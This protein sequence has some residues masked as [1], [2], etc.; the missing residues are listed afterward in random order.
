VKHVRK[1]FIS[2][3]S[4]DL[5]SYRLAAEDAVKKAG[6]HPV[7]M[8]YWAAQGKRP[9]LEACLREV[10]NCDVLIV[11]VGRRYG[12]VPDGQ[13]RSD[14]KSIAWLECERA[15]DQ[16]HEVIPFLVNENDLWPAEL[17]EEY[18]LV[19]AFK[20][21]R[22]TPE[23][24]AEVK[25][26]IARLDEFK[27]WLSGLGFRGTFTN[28]DELKILVLQALLG[29]DGQPGDATKYLEWLHEFT[30]W[31]DIR[32]LHVGHSKVYRFP[33]RELYTPLTTAAPNRAVAIPDQRAGHV[34]DQDAE[35]GEVRLEQVLTRR[36]VVI[37][38]DAGS[39][40]TT[41]LRR[42][43]HECCAPAGEFAVAP[44]TF[45]IFIR[46]GELEQHIRI[47]ND[48][49]QTGAPTTLES[50]DWLLHFLE[51]R[52]WD[53]NASYFD[54]RM[55]EEQTLVLLD[56]LDEAPNSRTRASMARLFENVTTRYR[57]CRF[58]ITTRPGA[59]H[60]GATLAGFDE[61]KVN[62]LSD[63][64]VERFL[65]HWSTALFPS[66]SRA[67]ELH[68]SE[69]LAAVRTRPGIQLMAHNP[70]MLTA[71]AVLHWNNKRLPEQRAELYEL[72]L[73]WLASARENRPGRASPETCLRL[74]S[75]LALGMQTQASGRVRQLGKRAAAEIILSEFHDASERQRLRVAEEFLDTE[76]VDSGIVVSRGANVEFWHLTF[77]E[78]LAARAIAGLTDATQRDFLLGN[79]RLFEPE[80][81]EIVL[82]YA[83]LLAAK[84]GLDK[85]EAFFSAVLDT[86]S[87]EISDRVRYAALL[88][89]LLVDLKPFGYQPRDSRYREL[90][91]VAMVV[92][93]PIK[94]AGIP[95]ESKV[96]AAEA[97]GRAGDPRFRENNWVRIE[98]G[99]FVMGKV[100]EPY[101]VEHT[102]DL[103]AFELGTYPVTV[104]EYGRF[105]EEGG[106]EPGE[107]NKQL[108]YP[109]RPVV[110]VSWY[111]AE[112][113]C[114]W[115]G[116]R[117][118]TDAEWERAK[119]GQERRE[120][121]WG[122]D[123]PDA[124]RA[125]YE[126]TKIGAPTPV[127][128]FSKG[129]TRD[130]IYDLWGNVWEWVA[131][132]YSEYPIETQR[133]LPGPDKRMARGGS[134]GWSAG[135][136]RSADRLFSKPETRQYDIGFRCA[137]GLPTPA[138]PE[139]RS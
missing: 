115:S 21:G 34:Y 106:P 79:A 100:N 83:G 52:N 86:Q 8:E 126:E 37:V 123:E 132:R 22:F 55:R 11:I 14:A 118:P 46:I 44:G 138:V 12:W 16:G 63:Q 62:D 105:F 43:A 59:Y 18:R 47:C 102:V 50:P 28:A 58:L 75:Y 112:A 94:S 110:R 67:A 74:L 88:G 96:G 122:N 24:P 27:V 3:T 121:P 124:T 45:P 40:K 72:I 29:T 90:M 125:N 133:I 1:V 35:H 71:F 25:R 19:E 119:R 31:I 117:L 69:L 98:A 137:R 89:V 91:D 108:L 57:E 36:R 56:G 73:V 87:S 81:R 135:A 23:L 95:L 77:Q 82:L 76:E 54:G 93:D 41:F 114:K 129:S 128:L 134:C 5:R 32:G 116:A 9:P 51:S 68:R 136:L 84:Q 30:A 120:Y 48:R 10:T 49:K 70:V 26:N 127:G 7:M 53:L 139:G 85:V 33:I 38:G 80:W 60:T 65:G 20:E 107:W 61:V 4:E 64:S 13:P 111:D 17:E 97:V 78:H 130:G 66:D 99:R 15:R 131:T 109:N 113:Y 39:G 104:Q 2:S 103:D 92:F 42:L 101:E 6:C